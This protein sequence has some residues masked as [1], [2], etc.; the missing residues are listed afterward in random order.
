MAEQKGEGA[1][2]EGEPQYAGR[3][4]VR[5]D[6]DRPSGARMSD[7][8]LGGQTNYVIDRIAADEVIRVFPAIRWV[9]RVNQAFL[10][11]SVRFLAH[12]RGI[13]QF[14]EIGTGIPTAE[15]LHEAVMR[16]F[17]EVHVAYVDSD[18]VVLRYGEIALGGSALGRTAYVEADVSDPRALLDAV[19]RAHHLDFSRPM[20]VSLNGL[21]PFLPD[22]QDPY[23]IVGTLAGL[24]PPGSFLTLSHWTRDFDPTAWAAVAEVYAEAGTPVQVRSRREVL[25]FFEGMRL[26]DPGLVIAHRWRPEPA[27]G[28]SLISDAQA[29]LYAAVAQIA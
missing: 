2:C 19:K 29:S 27:S 7:Y 25:R 10:V 22:D 15:H 3:T 26:V 6:Q 21:L 17:P 23:G 9:A 20:G 18:P 14:L 8:F 24:L 11:R 1:M 12:E 13:R 16:E 4:R 5:L 28:P